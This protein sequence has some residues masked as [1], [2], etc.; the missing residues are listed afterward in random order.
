MPTGEVPEVPPPGSVP[1]QHLRARSR[2]TAGAGPWGTPGRGSRP[3]GPSPGTVPDGPGTGRALRLPYGAVDAAPPSP[4]AGPGTGRGV[5]PGWWVALGCTVVMFAGAGIAYYGLAVFLRPL[6][7]AHGWS[8]TLVSAAS[9]MFY[10]ITGLSSAWVGP[11]ID[12]SGPRRPMLAGVA[13]LVAGVLAVG[14]ASRPWHLFV[15]YGLLALAFGVGTVVPVN[16]VMARWF[17]ARRGAAMAVAA[18]GVSLGGIVLAPLVTWLI[19]RGGL[20]LAGIVLAVGAAAL[21]VPIIVRV[22]VFDPAERGLPPDSWTGTPV[23][24]EVLA[25][26]QRRWTVKAAAR[27]RSFWALLAGFVVVLTSQTG[28][29]VHEIAFLEDRMGS[30]RAAAFAL[31]VTAAGSIVARLAVGSVADRLDVRRVTAVIFCV[32]ALALWGIV[33]TS[34]RTLTWVLVLVFGFT[35]GNVY[36]MQ[37][38]LVGRIFGLVSFGTVFGALSLASQ[39]GSGVGPFV[40]GALESATGSYR[41]PLTVTAAATAVAALVITA[42][43][44]VRTPPSGITHEVAGAA[45]DPGP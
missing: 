43:R 15:A 36:L 39:I 9:G 19:E 13:L 20:R 14:F 29:V 31:S 7:D 10:V 2:L 22:I 16:A 25:D 32:Q 26:Q 17:I 21:L 8:N 11:R 24:G 28:F 30:R 44:P 38:L 33:S 35:I 3:T 40:I 23:D 37:S 27:T 1:P 41:L 42:A 4:T 6:R 34:S 5:Y 12:R 18:S 45:P